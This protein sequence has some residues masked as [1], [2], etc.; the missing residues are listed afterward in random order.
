MKPRGHVWTRHLVFGAAPS[1]YAMFR[2]DG[3]Y[4]NQVWSQRATSTLKQTLRT[5]AMFHGHAHYLKDVLSNEAV[6]FSFWTSTAGPCRTL[7]P[8]NL[9]NVSLAPVRTPPLTTSPAPTL[10]LTTHSTL[11]PARLPPNVFHPLYHDST[12]LPHNKQPTHNLLLTH[13]NP[14]SSTH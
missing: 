9:L 13:L 1:A 11:P 5:H 14:P 2:D 3:N 10:P 8:C 6:P 4:G 12:N 7:W